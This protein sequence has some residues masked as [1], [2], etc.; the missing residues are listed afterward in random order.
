MARVREPGQPRCSQAVCRWR[1]KWAC[2]FK[3]L[4][5]P[6][7]SSA[8]T[9]WGF[10]P[11]KPSVLSLPLSSFYMFARSKW[12]LRTC[13]YMHIWGPV[14]IKDEEGKNWM[15]TQGWRLLGFGAQCLSPCCGW[16]PMCAYVCVRVPS[17]WSPSGRHWGVFVCFFFQRVFLFFLI[18]FRLIY[19]RSHDWDA[20]CFFF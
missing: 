20:N 16:G 12:I 3:T 14:S 2:L 13:E 6:S 1:G 4:T 9:D 7:S 15:N 17:C 8:P 18:R 11:L 19:M 10:F 5:L